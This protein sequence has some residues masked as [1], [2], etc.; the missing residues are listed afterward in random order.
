MI[1]S[2]DELLETLRAIAAKTILTKEPFQDLDARC[3]AGDLPSEWREGVVGDNGPPG[4]DPG[5]DDLTVPLAIECAEKDKRIAELEAE[6]AEAREQRHADSAN[7]VGFVKKTAEA[8]AERDAALRIQNEI[9]AI[10]SDEATP[11]EDPNENVA[12]LLR[13]RHDRLK[14]ELA[15]AKRVAAQKLNVHAAEVVRERAHYLLRERD[16]A[17]RLIQVLDDTIPGNL[18][19]DIEPLRAAREAFDAAQERGGGD[20]E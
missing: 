9:L 2:P 12:T 14:D 17:L 5:S 16:A 10:W 11:D 6:L 8:I 3:K 13:V 4:C 19:V 1:P 18:W 20:E 15:E 7:V